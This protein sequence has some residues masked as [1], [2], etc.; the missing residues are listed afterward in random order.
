MANDLFIRIKMLLDGS[1]AQKGMDDTAAKAET[2][3]ARFKATFAGVLAANVVQNLASKVWDFGKE[4]VE[5]YEKAE[6]TQ[7]KFVDAM[8]RIPGASAATTQAL[9]DQAKALSQVT[10]YSAGQSKQA[11][12]SLASFGLTGDQLR[13]L[14]PLVQDYAAK[15]GKDLPTAAEQVGKA[16]LGQGRALK[17]IGLDFKDTGS[18]GGNFAEIVGGLQGK[19]GGLAE[20][21]GE[22]SAGKMQ[23][24]QNQTMA[25][26]VALGSALVPALEQAMGIIKPLMS[27]IAANTKWLVPLAAGIIAV[28]TAFKILNFVMGLFMDNPSALLI[29]AIAAAVVLLGVALYELITHWDAVWGA[30]KAGAEAVW[31]VMQTV[32]D[33][34]LGVIQAVWSWIVSNW[35]LL[36]GILTGPI[37]LAV[38]LIVKYWDDIWGAIQAVWSWIASA[39]GAVFGWITAPFVA[40]WQW[41]VGVWNAAVGFFAGLISGIASWFGRIFGIITAPFAQAWAWLSA[42]VAQV[43]AW[44]AGIPGAIARALSSVFD[45]ITAPFKKAFDFINSNIIGPLKSV[46]NG[47]AH[48][49]NAIHIHIPGLSLFGHQI[50]PDIDWRP[51][52]SLPTL[53]KGG[54]M[55]RSGLVYAHAGEV[56]SPA[57]ASVTSSGPA[58]VIQNATFRDEVMIDVFMRKAA[59]YLQ[60]ER[61]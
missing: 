54:L 33:A 17:G 25:L 36:L 46:W 49:F 30:I 50:I 37:G 28:A 47:I 60:T 48:T 57:P 27:F 6:Q 32:W 23:I 26:K 18:L 59:W 11:L 58:V 8:S 51:P 61:V 34:I 56:I 42:T 4:S 29:L 43:A 15:T 24:F 13:T 9:T 35:P 2:F 10:V 52:F 22:T 41:I 45:T 19:V 16:L 1:Q 40:A 20:Q 7:A 21:M 38:V 3:G 55:T 31:Q 12:A 39:F 44:F 53:A 14:L 5:A